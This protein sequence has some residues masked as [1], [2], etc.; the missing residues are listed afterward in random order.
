M[1]TPSISGNTKTPAR[2]AEKERDGREQ[3][4][5]SDRVE[6]DRNTC[7]LCAGSIELGQREA[8]VGFDS[9]EAED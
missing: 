2:S 1:S 9:T 6:L 8:M 7:V 5:P 3:V 4:E